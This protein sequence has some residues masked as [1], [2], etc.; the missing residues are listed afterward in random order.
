MLNGN[1]TGVGK[2]VG[3]VWGEVKQIEDGNIPAPPGAVAL[4]APVGVVKTDRF[5]PWQ[6]L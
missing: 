2:W 3:R 6:D 5:Q 1:L 4:V